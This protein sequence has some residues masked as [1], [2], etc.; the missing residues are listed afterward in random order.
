MIKEFGVVLT[1]FVLVCGSA[2]AKEKAIWNFLVENDSISNTDRNYTNGGRIGYLSP[3]GRGERLARF[4]LGAK[5]GEK[6]RFGIALGQSIFTPQDIQ[7]TAPLPDQHPYAGWLYGEFSA[8]VERN[9]NIHD[10]LAIDLGV[11]GPSALGRQ[12]QNNFHK[13]IGISGAK[14]WANQLHDEPGLIVTFE[15][16]WR[17]RPFTSFH[18]V[19]ADITPTA[20]FSAGNVLTQ[21]KAGLTFRVGRNLVGNYGPP[22]VR[23][24]LSGSGTYESVDGLS[25]YAFFGAEGRAVA[26]TIFLD[27]NTFRKSLSVNKRHLVADVQTGIA[28]QFRD[29]QI[30]Y[31]YVW[32]TRE[33][34][35]QTKRH[36]FGSVSISTKF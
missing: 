31:T 36:E 14:G 12:V 29:V 15:R 30:T 18:G 8:H 2:Q 7:A 26:H 4:L 25:W 13:L 6:T 22:R 11:V 9:N 35:T 34:K 28:L 19:S 21:G 1:L 5:A 32:R 23:P 3:T 10:T 20:G 17:A 33:F 27:G 24:S 16:K